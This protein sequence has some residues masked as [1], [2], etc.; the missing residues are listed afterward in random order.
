[1]KFEELLDCGHAPSPHSEITTGYGE[2]KGKR[3]C[4]ACCAERDRTQMREHGYIDLYLVKRERKHTQGDGVWWITN[5]PS[6]LEFSARHIRTSKHG[7]GFG[8]QRTDAWFAFDGFW[9]HAINRGEMQI[10]RC[11]KTKEKVK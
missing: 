11:R 1:M 2:Y 6:S 3:Y 8:S 9:W 10:A 4:Y 5:W 7:G